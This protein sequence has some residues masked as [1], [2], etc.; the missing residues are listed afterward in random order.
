MMQRSDEINELAAALAKAQSEIRGA[1]KD[2]NNSHFRSD[3]AT[4]QSVWDACREPLTKHGLSIVQAPGNDEN[5]NVTVETMLLHSS[6]QWMS[7]VLAC[8]PQ[9]QD[10]QGLGSVVTY[11]RRYALAAVGGIA[12]ADD[13]GEAGSGRGAAPSQAPPQMAPAQASVSRGNKGA[14][15][16]ADKMHKRRTSISVPEAPGPIPRCKTFAPALATRPRKRPL[17]AA[18]EVDQSKV[19]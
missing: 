18:S 11:L 15:S 1:V 6:G 10:A 17:N 16:D 3:Y 4:L 9:K 5:G 19:A 7:S 12:Q 13:D 8:K 14:G 2:A